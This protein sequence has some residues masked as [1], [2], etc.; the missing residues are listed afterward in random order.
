MSIA[1]PTQPVIVITLTDIDAEAS[2]AIWPR[3]DYDAG[4]LAHLADLVEDA[5]DRGGSGVALDAL[6][7]IYVAEAPGLGYIVADGLHRAEAH[8][9]ADLTQIKAII[10]P[11]GTDAYLFALQQAR[12][13]ATK[14]TTSDTRHNIFA[15]TDDSARSLTQGQIAALVGV[16]QGR[17]SQ[18]V[19]ERLLGPNKATP[20]DCGKPKAA[21]VPRRLVAAVFA[22]ADRHVD[23]TTWESALVELD[24][25]VREERYE[26]KDVKAVFREIADLLRQWGKADA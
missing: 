4:T 3:R 22:M 9:I 5:R 1:V 20:E 7:P 6:D 23:E 2:A 11:Y 16:T 14:L 8:R 13:A 12:N 21:A 26:E 15:L 24:D 25:V 18:V 19:K 10:L 17:V